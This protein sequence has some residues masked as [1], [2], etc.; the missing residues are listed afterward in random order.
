[1]N[2]VIFSIATFVAVSSTIVVGTVLLSLSGLLE[3]N[4]LVAYGLAI[5]TG[6]ETARRVY[7]SSEPR[8]WPEA[9]RLSDGA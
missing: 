8:G 1:M 9:H 4:A 5:V 7:R 6:V 2:R 3:V